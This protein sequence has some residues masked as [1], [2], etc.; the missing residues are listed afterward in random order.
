ATVSMSRYPP[1]QRCTRARCSQAFGWTER[2]CFE[3]T[4]RPCSGSCNRA[5]RP[6]NMPRSWLGSLRRASRDRLA[7]I[8][9]NGLHQL[10]HPL[11]RR[12]ACRRVAVAAQ[13]VE[14]DHVGHPGLERELRLHGV[15]EVEPDGHLGRAALD[16]AAD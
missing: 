13:R 15:G 4:W 2:P 14:D 10:L 11:A 12:G 7:A 9:L 6:P 1:T 8:P 3:T 16:L 5:W